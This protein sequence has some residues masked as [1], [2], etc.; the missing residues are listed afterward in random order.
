MS[1]SGCRNIWYILLLLAIEDAVA[2]TWKTF[3]IGE[4]I[5]KTEYLGL[6]SA[7]LPVC[8][9]PS[10]L[11]NENLATY[12]LQIGDIS[13]R[14]ECRFDMIDNETFYSITIGWN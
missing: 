2:F 14:E 3:K 9:V 13:V 1:K 4:N 5:F 8:E 10:Y 12:M 6:R 11:V 7:T